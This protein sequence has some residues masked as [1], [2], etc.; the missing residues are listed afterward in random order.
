MWILLLI[1][2]IGLICC[3]FIDNDIG[4]VFSVFGGMISFVALIGIL[5]NIGIL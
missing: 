3:I 1:I 5:V 2:G 4:E